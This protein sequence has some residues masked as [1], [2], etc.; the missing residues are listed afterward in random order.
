MSQATAFD[1]SKPPD[2]ARL[3]ELAAE[4]QQLVDD[5]KWSKDEFE[6]LW[7]AGKKAVHGHLDFL[8]CLTLHADPD[9]L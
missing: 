9:W 3:Q 4:A 8:E 7:T 1:D 6:R 5:D 2:W